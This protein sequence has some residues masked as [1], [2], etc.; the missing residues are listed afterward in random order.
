MKLVISIISVKIIIQL[1]CQIGGLMMKVRREFELGVSGL[2][3]QSEEDVQVS[4]N[5]IDKVKGQ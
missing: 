2:P 3:E 4:D 1:F 5:P